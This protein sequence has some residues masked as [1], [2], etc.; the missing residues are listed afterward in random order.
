MMEKRLPGI[1]FL[2][3]HPQ[4]WIQYRET[5][6]RANVEH[7]GAEIG[8]KLGDGVFCGAGLELDQDFTLDIILAGSRRSPLENKALCDSQLR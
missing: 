3:H 6:K 8:V 2:G 4:G 1:R 7:G 5:C